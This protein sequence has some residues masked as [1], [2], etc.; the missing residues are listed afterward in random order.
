MPLPAPDS[1][2]LL[3]QRFR[4]GDQKAAKE[5]VELLY[6]ELRQLARLHMKRERGLP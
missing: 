6:P 5:L 4:Q 2:S 1:I 3:I